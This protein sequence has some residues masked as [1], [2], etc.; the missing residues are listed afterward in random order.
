VLDRPAPMSWP[1]LGLPGCTFAFGLFRARSLNLRKHLRFDLSDSRGRMLDLVGLDLA[2]RVAIEVDT[3]SAGGNHFLIFETTDVEAKCAS[4]L[5]RRQQTG[6]GDVRLDADLERSVRLPAL[7]HESRGERFCQHAK[8]L[9][10]SAE[11][12]A[13]IWSLRLDLIFGYV[14]SV[15]LAMLNT[16]RPGTGGVHNVAEFRAHSMQLPPGGGLRVLTRRQVLQRRA[17]GTKQ[18][19]G[20]Q[21]SGVN[22]VKRT[23]PKPDVDR[24]P[25]ILRWGA[26][27]IELGVGNREAELAQFRAQLL[28]RVP[29][30]HGLT[31]HVRLLSRTDGLGGDFGEYQRCGNLLLIFTTLTRAWTE[32]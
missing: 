16:I 6:R 27:L 2:G 1:H 20:P 12:R 24:R 3:R 28:S 15:D 9:Q 14:N 7:R 4:A 22:V 29:P 18:R 17:P 21:D 30:F 25:Q 5:A 8:R 10:C 13:V 32:A 26:H 23:T 19:F 11:P 31:S